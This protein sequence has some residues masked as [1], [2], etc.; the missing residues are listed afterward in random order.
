MSLGSPVGQFVDVVGVVRAVIIVVVLGVGRIV[1]IDEVIVG[2]VISVVVGVVVG[3][4]VLCVV[5]VVVVV[6]PVDT[7]LY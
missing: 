3:G 1:V 5:A 4:V 2:V 6:I 7:A